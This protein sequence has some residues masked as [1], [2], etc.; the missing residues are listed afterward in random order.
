[1]S[2][3][4]KAPKYDAKRI[5]IKLFIFT[6]KKFHKKVTQKKEKKRYKNNYGVMKK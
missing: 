1:M 3:L 5:K 4:K 2:N 6:L